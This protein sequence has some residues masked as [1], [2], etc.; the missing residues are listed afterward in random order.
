[1]IP[2]SSA[3]TTAGRSS[4]TERWADSSDAHPSRTTPARHTPRRVIMSQSMSVRC[5]ELSSSCRKSSC[6]DRPQ[7][8]SLPISW[9]RQSR[10]NA[11]SGQRGRSRR[12]RVRALDA[13]GGTGPRCVIRY[14]VAAARVLRH[15]SATNRPYVR[16]RYGKR[17]LRGPDFGVFV[18]V[19]SAEYAGRNPD[20]CPGRR[21]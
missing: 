3:T 19:N 12:E 20:Q 9:K 8:A 4:D 11:E 5:L 14:T 18:S 10:R 7:V 15:E 16:S 17:A 1:M 6:S 21:L 13:Y 2:S